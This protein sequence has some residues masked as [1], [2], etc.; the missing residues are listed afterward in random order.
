M[1]E[2]TNVTTFHITSLLERDKKQLKKAS[3]FDLT[4]GSIT[5]TTA[6][7]YETYTLHFRYQCVNILLQQL[8]QRTIGIS[9]TPGY[10]TFLFITLLPFA[11]SNYDSQVCLMLILRDGICASLYGFTPFACWS[12]IG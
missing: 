8:I 7:M 5:G 2:K 1:E 10:R 12:S 3:V 9:V 11:C 6:K 4:Q